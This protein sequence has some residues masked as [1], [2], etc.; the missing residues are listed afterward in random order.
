MGREWSREQFTKQN[1]PW[2]QDRYND[3]A[4]DGIRYANSHDVR[5]PPM[6]ID[7]ALRE[8]C[9]IPARAY[10]VGVILDDGTTAMF[11]GPGR[12]G[13]GSITK[14]F[15][16]DE[17]SRC[18]EQAESGGVYDDQEYGADADSFRHGFGRDFSGRKLSERRRASGMDPF[19]NDPSHKTRKRHRS[20]APR[21]ALNDDNDPPMTM[22]VT[23][24]GIRIGDSD[25][26][27]NFYQQRFKN[28]QQT[29]CKVISKAWVK[30]VEPK[31]Q[32]HH[33]YTGKDEKAPDWWPKPWGQTKDERVRHK[34][35]DHLYKKERVHLLTHILRLVVEPAQKQH[36]DVQKSNL[37]VKKLEEATTEALSSFFS[38]PENP[39]NIKKRPYLDEIFK[40]ARYEERYK[41]GEID[42]DTEVFVMADDKLPEFY[43]VETDTS[44][45]I[46]EKHDDQDPGTVRRGLSPVKQQVP[47]HSLLP[48]N[49]NPGSNVPSG[50]QSQSFLS[51]LPV[52][53]GAHLSTPMVH[54]DM[55]PEQ[56]SSFIGG[57]SMGGVAG[58]SI[59]HGATNL[60]MPEILTSPHDTPDRRHSLV[61]NQ[62]SDFPGPANTTMYPQHWQSSSA[63]PA[64]S[65][66]YT[67]FSHQQAAPAQTY[68]TQPAI[69][70]QQGQQQYIPQPYDPM[71]R[72]P[73]FDPSHGQMF[74]AGVNQTGVGHAQGG[75]PGY[76]PS[77]TRGMA[78]PN[79]GAK[80]DNLSRSH[81]Q[82]I[83]QQSLVFSN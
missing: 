74:R 31:K 70:I 66:M 30:A 54:A 44:P 48:T 28:C 40:V 6:G 22:A 58:T 75:Y 51:D 29:A 25:L 11:S 12:L 50:M 60:P 35:P 67:S 79:I 21:Q 8:H 81:M 24:Q 78:A 47:P 61:F 17:F 38:D 77:D 53:D 49:G 41:N 62:P 72:A 15:D 16:V 68:G 26:V 73:S 71:A 69:G 42:G 43:Q 34:E 65:P 13:P 57:A 33:P 5:R 45:K 32:S 27:W 76:L 7:K 2:Q 80:V 4:Q 23:K 52:R 10:F 19:D 18:V 3:Q 63:A 64:T 56:Q 9:N 83:S 55:N 46:H 37:N 36:P 39:G 1:H 59:H 82:S 20:H 14:F